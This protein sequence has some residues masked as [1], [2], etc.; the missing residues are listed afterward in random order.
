MNDQKRSSHTQDLESIFGYVE[1][2]TFQ[3]PDNGFTVARLQQD[4]KGD[5]TTIV[6]NFV[7]IKAGLSFKCNGKWQHN[8]QHGPQFHLHSISE[9]PP[10]SLHGIQ[11]YLESGLIKGIGPKYAKKIVERFGIQTLD[12]LEKTPEKLSQLQGI[13]KKRI[14]QISQCWIQHKSLNQVMIFL[15]SH[16]ITPAYAQKIYKNYGQKCIELLE[17]NPYRLAHEIKGIGFK[18]ADAIAKKMG[19]TQNAPERIQAGIEYVL[20]ELSGLGHVCFP[21]EKF[22]EHASEALDV[23]KDLVQSEIQTL[24]RHENIIVMPLMK[25]S[26]PVEHIWNRGLYISERG[27]AKELSRLRSCESQ[28]RKIDTEKAILW[29]EKKLEMELAPAQKQAIISALEDKVSIITGGPGTGKSTIC[30]AILNIFSQLTPR[31][32]LG[33]PTGKAAKRLGEITSKEAKTIHS[34][35]E[36]DWKL[37]GFKRN[38]KTPLECDLLI[39]DESSMIDTFLMYQLLRAIPNHCRLILIGDIHQLPSVGPGNILRD[40]INSLRIRTTILK[41]I[42]RQ[43][44]S[45]RIVTNA[46]RINKGVFPDISGGKQS[47]FFF[48][49]AEEKEKA[50]DIIINLTC[51]RIPKKF[52]WN[53][54]ED[55]QVLSPMKKGILGT[56]NLNSMLQKTLNPKEYPLQHMGRHFFPGDKVIQIRN[57]YK[58]EIYNG[59]IGIISHIDLEER[60]LSIS[61]DHRDIEYDF[62]ELDEIQLAYAL[63]IHKYQGSECPCMI[64]PIHTTH[65][66]MLQRNLLYTAVTRGRKLVVLVGTKKA[67]ALCCKNDLVKTRHTGLFDALLAMSSDNTPLYIVD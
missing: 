47:D 32:F 41:D 25:D 48:I 2:I 60:E 8:K 19:M 24:D 65:F 53:P 64:I 30:N 58:K 13:G 21:L 59:D 54:L 29:V 39:I 27:I 17:K 42:F 5:L 3:N 7:S 36:F 14:Q 46:H 37:Q 44:K 31:I 28:L 52:K 34:L 23:S 10:C 26:K 66:V 51:S 40:L 43:A 67:I 1:R 4:G 11:K 18:K 55:I 6:G 45:S 62:S 20:D 35:L 61:Y 15:Q 63:S 22:I 57:N 50:V 9:I 56:E 38:Q 16:D 12:I 49:Q 33:A